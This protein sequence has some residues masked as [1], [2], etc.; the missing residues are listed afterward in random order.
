MLRILTNKNIPPSKRKAKL[1]GTSCLNFLGIMEAKRE[2]LAIHR[3]VLCSFFYIKHYYTCLKMS[4]SNL[5]K[6]WMEVRLNDMILKYALQGGF[7]QSEQL[8]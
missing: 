1:K 7:L 4:T 2:R 5:D 8:M 6:I 3:K